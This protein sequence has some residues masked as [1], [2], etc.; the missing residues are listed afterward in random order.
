V[1][2]LL[3]VRNLVILAGVVALYVISGLLGLKV[4]KPEVT[5]V[6]EPIFHIGPLAVTNALLTTW[7]V[8]LLLVLIAWLATRHMPKDLDNATTAQLVPSGFQNFMEWVVEVIHG[9]VQDSAG[10]RTRQFFPVL[11]T[12][13]LFIIASNWLGLLPGFGSIG[14]LHHPAEG[15][16]FVVNG[17]IL[18]AQEATEAAPGYVLIPLF[19]SPSTD[20]NFTLALALISVAL[21]EYFGLRVLKLGYIK[22]FFDT[23][24]FKAGAMVGVAQF[25][26]GALELVGEFT[27]I[28]SFTF[29]L[30]GNVFAGEVLLGVIAF[31]VPYVVSLPFMGLELFVGFIQALVFMMITLVFL[32]NATVSHGAQEHS[33]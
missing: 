16:G 29:R 21:T 28:I 32:V 13:F 7:L 30:F 23:S 18:T 26:A 17:S 6:A 5:I 31:L 9:L 15:A 8:M 25:F 24:G 1:K 2:K 20:L 14:F 3:T 12:I 22:R 4:A 33:S 27:R 19:R 11:M 10:K